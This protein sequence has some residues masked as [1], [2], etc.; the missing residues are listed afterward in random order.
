VVK[1]LDA[2]SSVMGEPDFWAP[3]G[4]DHL[5]KPLV[6][7]FSDRDWEVVR[8]QLQTVMDGAITDGPFGRELLQMVLALP[9]AT[10]ALFDR[11]RAAVLL[12]HGEWDALRD[13]LASMPVQPKEISGIG[14]LIT[15]SVDRAEWPITEELHELLTVQ[16]YEYQLRA[17]MGPLRHWAQR[18]SRLVPE[19]I[20]RREDIPLGRHLRLR[21]LHDNAML[22]V[23]EAHAGRLDVAYAL[24]KE[25]QRLG[26]E[27]DP[28]RVV[29]VDLA[30]LIRVAVGERVVTTL[31]VPKLVGMST[32]PSPL[33][34][35]Q[36]L[37]DIV[38]FVA[39]TE[40]DALG[41]V[42]RVIERIAARMASPRME[43]QAQ[44]WRVAAELRAGGRGRETELAGVLSKA[45]HATPGL[46]AL[47][48]FLAGYAAQRYDDFESAEELARHA[49]NVWLQVSAMVWMTA[50][51]PNER[52]ARRLRQLLDITG[53][54]RPILVPA[55]IAAEA[56]L[57]MT[58]VG[59]RAES[60]IELAVAADRMN[61]TLEVIKRHVEGS[62]APAAVRV[63]A[64]NAL[65]RI[66]TV[67]ARELLGQLTKR[68]DDVGR[69]ATRL[70]AH[71]Q[72]GE[73]LSEREIE[74]L[75]LAADG[76]TNRQIGD[77]LYLSPHTVARHIVNARLKLG[78]A[79]RTEAATRLKQRQDS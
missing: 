2:I 19:Y 47:P 10:D 32:G 59:Q 38:A 51:D 3:V 15:A 22:A 27:N 41:W 44:S 23:G 30:D 76:L 67:H 57:G 28:L 61:V 46:K 35:W 20:W 8:R 55:E 39:L 58:A 70:A 63:T 31:H 60:V 17:T 12:D 75:R 16:V 21:R 45:R 73:T 78:A 24:A 37:Y 50:L 74:V 29:A 71:V 54:R 62:P 34:T 68:P 48:T 40:D 66:N 33:G 72:R 11:Y 56:A 69:T 7:A 77:R 36:I 42:A 1:Q 25:A 53:W 64:V 26:D 18:I 49:G 13:T 9:P 43:L 4:F 52:V 14:E 79:N 6:A 65:A 5:P